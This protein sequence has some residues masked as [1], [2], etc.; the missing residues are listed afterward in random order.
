MI[1]YDMKVAILALLPFTLALPGCPRNIA[2]SKVVEITSNNFMRFSITSF[3]AKPGESVTVRYN[4]VGDLPKEG[5]AHNWVLLAKEADPPKFVE[6]GTKYPE[7][8]Y[9]APAQSGSVLA[10]T[11]MLGPGESDSI[12]FVA[13]REPGAYNYVC[14]FPQHYGAGMRGVMTVRP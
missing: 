4:N 1:G 9:I 8:D 6:A 7:T 10:R 14:T 11:K 12:T 5:M 2:P 3:E 13:P